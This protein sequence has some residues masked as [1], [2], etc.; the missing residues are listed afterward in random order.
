MTLL[1]SWIDE[2]INVLVWRTSLTSVEGTIE[3]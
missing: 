1:D 3:L 2:R